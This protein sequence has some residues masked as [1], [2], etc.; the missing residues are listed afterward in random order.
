MTSGPILHLWDTVGLGVVLA[1]PSGVRYSN[2]TGGHACLHPELEGVYVPVRNDVETE[3]GRF[4]SPEQE[5][6][7]HFM[8]PKHAGRGARNGLD[9]EDADLMDAV[10]RKHGLDRVMHVDRT[11]L[12]DSHEAW[13]FVLVTGEVGGGLDLFEGF[14]PY[15]RPGVLTWA[16]SD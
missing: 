15:P 14:G 10:L 4:L 16:N 2:Q 7:D 11:R 8:G 9:E 3:G 6:F 12:A 13:V 1:H 5:L